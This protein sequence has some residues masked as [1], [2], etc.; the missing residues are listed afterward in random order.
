MLIPA[1]RARS[2]A[3]ASGASSAKT[4]RRFS[5]RVQYR[6][7]SFDVI[8]SMADMAPVLCLRIAPVSAINR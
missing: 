5:A 6:R 1:L 8:I 7:F 4:Q 2:E 3:F